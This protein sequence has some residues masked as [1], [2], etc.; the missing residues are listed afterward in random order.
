MSVISVANF[1]AVSMEAELKNITFSENQYRLAFIAGSYFP[2]LMLLS[3]RIN[4]VN[5]S[6]LD[7]HVSA[8]YL[9]HSQVKFTGNNTFRNNT[10]FNGG[11]IC[12]SGADNALQLADETRLINPRRACARV[13][14]LVLSVCPCVF[15]LFWHLAQS[16]VQTA[17]SATSA[18]Y[19]HEI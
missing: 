2:Q 11:A 9:N 3:R 4:L 13:T 15:Y 19:G 17:V 10:S 7:G 8:L 6:C 5:C 14:V 1:V 16:G 18:R 12:I